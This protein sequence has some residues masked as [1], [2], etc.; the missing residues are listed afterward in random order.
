MFHQLRIRHHIIILIIIVIKTAKNAG[1]G[2]DTN[3]TVSH[4]FHTVFK[5]SNELDIEMDFLMEKGPFQFEKKKLKN[6]Q[7]LL[8]VSELAL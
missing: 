8:R 5:Q 1:R 4:L 2:D 6:I 7:E 3:T